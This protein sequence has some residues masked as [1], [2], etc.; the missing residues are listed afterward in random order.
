MSLS[1]GDNP[2]AGQL[3]ATTT[4]AALGSQPCTAVLIQADPGNSQNVLVG[5]S[6]NQYVVVQAGRSLVV[7]CSNVNLVYAKSVSGTQTVNWLAVS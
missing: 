2:K 7:P 3:A 6:T 4:A 1:S 5:D